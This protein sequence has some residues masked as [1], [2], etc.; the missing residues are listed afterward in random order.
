MFRHMDTNGDGTIGQE[1]FGKAL[2]DGTL[3][4][5]LTANTLTAEGKNNN[6]PLNK[7][8]ANSDSEKMD[9]IDF[10]E[11]CELVRDRGSE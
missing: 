10:A 11:Y 2:A 4:D 6:E 9:A 5:A 8:S 7:S 3:L 1:E